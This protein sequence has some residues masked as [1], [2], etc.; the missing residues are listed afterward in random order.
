M[1]HHKFFDPERSETF[2]DLKEE[3]RIFFG[4][5]SLEGRFG[6]DYFFVPNA[7]G[8]VIEVKD[9]TFGLVTKQTTFDSTFDAIIGLAYPGMAENAG[10]PLFDEMMRQEL[11][12]KNVFSFYLTQNDEE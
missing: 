2:I 7:K 4:S 12:T 3:A 1:E 5:G 6:Q 9:Q 11:L 8:E 10:I